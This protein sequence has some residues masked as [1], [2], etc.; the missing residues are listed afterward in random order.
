MEIKVKALKDGIPPGTIIPLTEKHGNI[1]R[2][3]EDELQMQGF[4]V[5]RGFGVD[6]PDY[7]LEL[8]TRNIN[9]TSAQT[10]TTCTTRLLLAHEWDTSPVSRKMKRQYRVLYKQRDQNSSVV[11]E[12]GVFD[13]TKSDIQSIL[14][15]DFNKNRLFVAQ[16]YLQHGH[17]PT[18][19]H[20]G[21]G[22]VKFERSETR[23]AYQIRIPPRKMNKLER[24]TKQVQLFDF[25]A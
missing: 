24:M 7:D 2:W 13:F 8:K 23:D 6:L 15:N 1:G 25:A 16:F 4:R 18:Y 20:A 17:Y 14:A 3:V 12:S 5:N 10:I 22:F 19:V 21:N 11:V 9:A